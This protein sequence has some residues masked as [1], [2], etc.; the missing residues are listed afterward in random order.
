MHLSANAMQQKRDVAK[1]M[2]EPAQ[3]GGLRT[4]CMH[5]TLADHVF[6]EA[7]CMDLKMELVMRSHTKMALACRNTAACIHRGMMALHDTALSPYDRRSRK[8]H[9]GALG[10]HKKKHTHTHTHTHAASLGGRVLGLL[11]RDRCC[12]L[13]LEE[14]AEWSVGALLAN[15]SVRVVPDFVFHAFACAERDV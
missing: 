6:A 4:D 13:L 2:S 1:M 12:G 15:L 7:E 11:L 8:K 5:A 3:D 14:G 9:T 10:T